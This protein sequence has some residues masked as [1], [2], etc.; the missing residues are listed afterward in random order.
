MFFAALQKRRWDGAEMFSDE[1]GVGGAPV[2]EHATGRNLL[3][4]ES[5]FDVMPEWV[6]L[7][8]WSNGTDAKERSRRRRRRAGGHRSGH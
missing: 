8:T 6:C 5:G 7:E 4:G 1:D 2:F 3:V